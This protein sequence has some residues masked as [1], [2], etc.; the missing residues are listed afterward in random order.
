MGDEERRVQD[1]E[2]RW[3]KEFGPPISSRR[4]WL[5]GLLL[6]GA[7][8]AIIALAFASAPTR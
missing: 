3:E 1:M 2:R 7:L 6:I 5:S 4:K 8:V